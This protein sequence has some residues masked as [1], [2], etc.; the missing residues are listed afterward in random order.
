MAVE[1]T[2]ESGRAL[3][4]PKGLAHGFQTLLDDTEMSYQMT[5]P[6]EPGA[7]RGIRWNDP[8][9]DITWPLPDPILHPRDAAYADYRPVA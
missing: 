3:F 6:Y 9:L 5:V 7:G 1:L 2:E 4:I 8:L